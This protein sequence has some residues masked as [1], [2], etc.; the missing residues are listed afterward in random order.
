MLVNTAEHATLGIV[1][2]VLAGLTWITHA[3]LDLRRGLKEK[4]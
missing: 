4:T 2:L 3:L 1:M